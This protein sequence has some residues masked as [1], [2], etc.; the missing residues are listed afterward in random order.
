M[1]HPM[2]TIPYSNLRY[3]SSKKTVDDRALNKDVVERLRV[4]LAALGDRVPR[5]LEIGAGLGN[6]IARLA[7]WS[8]LRRAE[9]FVLDVDAQ[10]LEASRVR[11]MDWAHR[12]G[13]TAEFASE[14]LRIHG[15]GGVELTIRTIHAELGDYL[16]RERPTSPR[17]DL[18]IANAVL[19]LVDLST[20]LPRLLDLAVPDGL[21]WF[22][23]NYDGETILQPP[24]AADPGFMRV[25]NR[26]MDQ[27]IRYGRPAGDSRT[28][29]H[30]FHHLT[31]ARASILGAGASDW[32]VFAKD[33]RY[34]ADEAYFLH[35]IIRTIDDELG[36]Q[37]EQHAEIAPE[38][39][40][41]WVALRH[42]QIESGD[43]VYIAHQID[44]L[45]RRQPPAVV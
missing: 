41:H 32:V 1:E 42:A 40:A 8:V 9:Y 17:A 28:G 11:L 22:S 5:V 10:I 27:R 15:T 19:D 4:E 23:I 14:A 35:H 18:L 16:E 26:S 39:L 38:D 7:D 6:M 36:R 29:R 12:Q 43:L 20:T 34:E 44:F 21:F 30:L 25:Y 3:L 37:H 31:N 45:G 24:H 2:A 13:H 33:A